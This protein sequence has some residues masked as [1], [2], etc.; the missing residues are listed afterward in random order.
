MENA[1]TYDLVAFVHRVQ[2]QC[3]EHADSYDDGE[4]SQH[5]V[6]R[7]TRALLLGHVSVEECEV[8]G[9]LDQ[10]EVPCGGR[11]DVTDVRVSQANRR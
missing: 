6:L 7:P 5:L 8:D 11:D 4:V 2:A 1:A 3:Q 10:W 9:K